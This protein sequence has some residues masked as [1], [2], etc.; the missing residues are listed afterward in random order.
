[1]CIPALS[2]PPPR[3]LKNMQFNT[4]N[5]QLIFRLL[6]SQAPSSVSWHLLTHLLL[7]NN[8][9]IPRNGFILKRI[10]FSFDPKSQLVSY[11]V[12]DTPL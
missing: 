7:R 1:M 10:R 5:V 3:P 12:L 11:I 6:A 9:Y 8:C 2:C 4:E